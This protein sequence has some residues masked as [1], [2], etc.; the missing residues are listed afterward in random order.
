M[1]K[2]NETASKNP[3]VRVLSLL[4]AARLDAESP[5]PATPVSPN[6]VLWENP[7]DIKLRNLYYGPGGKEQQPEEPL[8]FE[9]EDSGGTN[10]KFDVRDNKGTKWKAKLGPEARPETAATCSAVGG[11]LSQREIFPV[12]VKEIP[13]N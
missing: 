8:T 7:G 13:M 12:T 5:G 6:A 1:G 9:E 3:A 11:R 4:L 10:P 2:S